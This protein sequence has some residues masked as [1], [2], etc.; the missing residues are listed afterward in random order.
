MAMAAAFMF[1]FYCVAL[2]I[3]DRANGKNDVK[4]MKN[5]NDFML[6][7]LVG[8]FVMVSVWGIIRFTQSV[9][10]DSFVT[11]NKMELQPVN[12]GVTGPTKTSTSNPSNRLP[13]NPTNGLPLNP[14]NGLPANP[15][16]GLENNQQ[17]EKKNCLG[18][19]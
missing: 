18:K 17:D 3:W 7:G 15:T 6:W 14:T 9:F 12:F 8:L 13:T 2:Y 16:N 11:S 5:A 4:E 10:G 19:V 1:F